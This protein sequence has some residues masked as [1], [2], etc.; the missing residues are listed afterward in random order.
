VRRVRTTA[1]YNAG[2]G[3]CFLYGVFEDEPKSKEKGE[4]YCRVVGSY[5]GCLFA[6]CEKRLS[7]RAI[8]DIDQTA[9]VCLLHFFICYRAFFNSDLFQRGLRRPPKEQ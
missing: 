4:D 2:K 8:V 9:P 3:P 6:H 7:K 1:N 5:E